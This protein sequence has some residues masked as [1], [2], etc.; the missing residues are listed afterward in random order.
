MSAYHGMHGHAYDFDSHPIAPPGIK[1]LIYESPQDRAFWAPHGVLGYYLGPALSHHRTFRVHCIHTRAERISDSLA[2]FPVAYRMPG[3]SIAE[4]LH[5]QITDLND[6]LTSISI[7]AHIPVN[8]RQP[9]VD[10]TVTATAALRAIASVFNPTIDPPDD[11]SAEQ[12][13]PAAQRLPAAPPGVPPA[14]AER[15]PAVPPG[16]SKPAPR[17]EQTVPITPAAVTPPTPSIPHALPAAEQRVHVE[18]PTPPFAMPPEPPHGV[19]SSL[20]IATHRSRTANA[21]RSSKQPQPSAKPF[22]QRLMKLSRLGGLAQAKL[23]N[24]I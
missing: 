24:G 22:H 8:A 2:W 19:R 5:A 11:P 14:D 18:H 9:F 15:T 17:A 10:A 1:V 20:R 13:V 3:S 7:T 16:L 12:R 21:M 23:T 4:L 6:T